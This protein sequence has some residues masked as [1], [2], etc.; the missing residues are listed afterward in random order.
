[1]LIQNIQ[2]KMHLLRKIV[3]TKKFG[4]LLRDLMY[5]LLYSC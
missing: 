3:E 4:V 5:N 2:D 1:M